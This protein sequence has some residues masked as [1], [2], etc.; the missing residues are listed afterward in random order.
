MTRVS[1]VGV[2]Q[3]DRAFEELRPLVEQ[4]RAMRRRCREGSRDAA[5]LDAILA[6]TNTAAYHFTRRPGFYDP[7]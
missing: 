2:L 1:Y 3:P 7:R 6:A 4:V 5:H